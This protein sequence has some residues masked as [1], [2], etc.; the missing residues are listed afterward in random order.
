MVI[1]AYKPNDNL[2]ERFRL[3]AGT[4]DGAWDF[5]RY[6]LTQLPHV[7]EKDDEVEVVAERQAYLLFDRM[8]A[9]HIQRGAS[10]PLSASEFYAG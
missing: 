2:E 9:F 5:M 4:S 10:V 1:S 3:E 7:V 6:H 8:V